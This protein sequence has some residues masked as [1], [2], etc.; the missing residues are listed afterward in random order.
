VQFGH[1]ETAADFAYD[2]PR[3]QYRQDD[4]RGH[5]HQDDPRGQ[6]RQDEA[7]AFDNDSA[8]YE[9]TG[10]LPAVPYSR[11]GTRS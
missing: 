4:P 6:Y 1:D 7:P 8:D 11:Y 5:F 2:D 9:E 10:P 3:G